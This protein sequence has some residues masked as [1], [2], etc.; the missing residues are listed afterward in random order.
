MATAFRAI[1]GIM[2]VGRG[3]LYQSRE[4]PPPPNVLGAL[5][6]HTAKE[7]PVARC[8]IFPSAIECY[9]V[10]DSFIATKTKVIH[11]LC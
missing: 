10:F 1:S 5:T 9:F 2:W 3:H 7:K 4:Y 6:F 8:C 11:L